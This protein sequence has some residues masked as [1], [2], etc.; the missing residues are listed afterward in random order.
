MITLDILKRWLVAPAENEI[1]EFKT[2]SHQFDT[3]RLLRYCV[4]LANE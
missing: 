1:L 3:T 2:A 4:A